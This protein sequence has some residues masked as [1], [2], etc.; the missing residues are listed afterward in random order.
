[1]KMAPTPSTTTPGSRFG[2]WLLNLGQWLTFYFSTGRARAS[3]TPPSGPTQAD[4][5]TGA[6]VERLRNVLY[7]HIQRE[8]GCHG[9][10]RCDRPA[11]DNPKCGCALEALS[12]MDGR[13]DCPHKWIGVTNGRRWC[14]DCGTILGRPEGEAPPRW[15]GSC[16]GCPYPDTCSRN[17]CCTFPF[18]PQGEAPQR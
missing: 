1:M 10:L 15:A 14:I 5:S 16:K 17:R 4:G 12:E 9:R 18:R 11:L 7:Q 13:P 8:N 3:P 6:D 2:R